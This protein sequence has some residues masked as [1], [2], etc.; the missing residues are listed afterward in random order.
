M[1]KELMAAGSPLQLVMVGL[2]LF[3]FTFLSIV[4]WTFRKGSKPKY[5]EVANIPLQSEE[6]HV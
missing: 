2:V 5:D 3:W 4:T 6:R 1:I